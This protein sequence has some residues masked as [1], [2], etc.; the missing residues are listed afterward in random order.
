MKARRPLL[1]LCLGILLTTGCQS[2]GLGVGFGGNPIPVEFS[3]LPVEGGDAT[4][5]HGIEA[6]VVTSRGW[7]KMNGKD[8]YEDLKSA[9][10]GTL[11]REGLIQQL[12]RGLSEHSIGDF[13]PPSK[14]EVPHGQIYYVLLRGEQVQ[15]ERF[16]SVDPNQRIR[17][18]R[19]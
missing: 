3:Y 5:Q 7:K 13:L 16:D 2:L 14:M 6:W 19:I 8:L 18:P 12:R 4:G 10:H 11:E 9:E 15:V 17:T 1:L